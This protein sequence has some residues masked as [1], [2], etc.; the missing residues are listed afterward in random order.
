[1]KRLLLSGTA[2]LLTASIMPVAQAQAERAANPDRTG[3]LVQITTTPFNLVSLAYRGYLSE[4]G[5]P[6][7]QI[8]TAKAR[9]HDLVAEDVVQA[10]VDLGRIPASTLEDSGYISSVATHMRHIVQQ[11]TD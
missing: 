9:H 8:F 10:G 1:M 11:D 7:Y 6:S 3:E 2:L 5:I 4:A